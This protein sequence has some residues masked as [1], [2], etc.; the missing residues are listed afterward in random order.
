VS[1]AVKV[2]LQIEAG[3]D[4][5]HA[6]LLEEFRNYRAGIAV[7]PLEARV[8]AGR[9]LREGKAVEQRA[10]GPAM[11]PRTSDKAALRMDG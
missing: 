3:H 10:P 8:E 7:E 4:L 9:T 6:S 11:Q 1:Q 2:A 5:D